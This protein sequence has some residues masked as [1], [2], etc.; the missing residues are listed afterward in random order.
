MT[1]FGGMVIGFHENTRGRRYLQDVTLP[2]ITVS[3]KSKRQWRSLGIEWNQV[4]ACFHYPDDI[5]AKMRFRGGVFP[6][7]HVQLR[8]PYKLASGHCHPYKLFLSYGTEY[9]RHRRLICVPRSPHCVTS[10]N[11]EFLRLSI[12]TDVIVKVH[13]GHLI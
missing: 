12:F 7:P 9:V 3:Y 8:L 5:E 2:Q 11:R 1:I 13:T 10:S 6:I 4:S